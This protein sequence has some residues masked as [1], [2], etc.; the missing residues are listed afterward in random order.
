[1]LLIAYCL[2][3][4]P[5]DRL[6]RMRAV[7]ISSVLGYVLAAPLL[8]PSEFALVA[9]NT[10]WMDQAGKMTPAKFLIIV[11]GLGVLAAASHATRDRLTAY[12]RFTLLFT[13]LTAAIVLGKSWGG[14]SLIAQPTRFHLA[15]E[16]AI[17]MVIGSLAVFVRMWHGAPLVLAALLSLWQ[18][19]EYRAYARKIIKREPPYE[20]SEYKIAHWLDQ[21]AEGNRVMVP[22]SV[23]FWLN[24]FTTTPQIGGCCDQNYLFQAPR[25]A[26]FEIGSDDG[27]GNRAAAISI[28][29]LK[30]VGVKYVA[31]SGPLSTEEYK[32]TH[33]PHKFDG[34][35]PKRWQDGDDAI[36]E[37]PGRRNSLAHWVTKSETITREPINGIDTEPLTAY[38]AAMDD[39]TRPQATLQ[40]TDSRTVQIHGHPRPGDLLSVQIPFPFRLAR[41]S[42]NRPR[43]SRLSAPGSKLSKRMRHHAHL[44]WRHGSETSRHRL[45][46]HVDRARVASVTGFTV[47]RSFSAA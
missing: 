20:R 4:D 9:Q 1:M 32:T 43:R 44:R 31:V 11:T 18:V 23:S 13:F 30:T 41:E 5:T 16:M 34:V 45:R 33:H 22:G 10:Q 15:M 14:F 42:T 47:A 25:T 36:F 28:T 37:V 35:L 2:A 21:H 26:V 24:A 29:W 12:A 46:A 38:T 7:A 19:G 40:W 17:V 3:A 27:A 6:P 8:P 39:E